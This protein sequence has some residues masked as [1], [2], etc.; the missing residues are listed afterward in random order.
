MMFWACNYVIKR[1]YWQA[2][3]FGMPSEYHEPW[4]VRK[5]ISNTPRWILLKMLFNF[6]EMIIQWQ[7]RRR[8]AS[9]CFSC[10][11]SLFSILR[12]DQSGFLFIGVS[13]NVF[14]ILLSFGNFL[15]MICQEWMALQFPWTRSTLMHC[16]VKFKM[17]C[18]TSDPPKH[19]FR[20]D[21]MMMNYT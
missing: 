7:W 10:F 14:L 6:R 16:F 3:V 8:P 21:D 4:H 1:K 20:M 5:H 17:I 12:M 13:K 18:R 11:D 9:F 19:A 2:P 15:K